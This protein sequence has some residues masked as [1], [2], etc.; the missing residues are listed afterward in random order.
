MTCRHA[1]AEHLMPGERLD[2]GNAEVSAIVEQFRC[3][4]CGAWLSLEPSNDHPAAVRVELRAAEFIA[5]QET[6]LAVI[7][8]GAYDACRCGDN[9]RR[10]RAAEMELLARLLAKEVNRHPR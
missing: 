3:V 1:N 6:A 2:L 7:K 10:I 8:A 9:R 5:C 4:D